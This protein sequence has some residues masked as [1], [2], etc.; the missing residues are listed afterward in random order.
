MILFPLGQASIVILLALAVRRS[1]VAGR[2]ALPGEAAPSA[3]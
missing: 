2:R 3:S 1:L